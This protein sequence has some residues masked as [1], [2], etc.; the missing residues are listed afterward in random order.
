MIAA[1]FWKLVLFSKVV[2]TLNEPN[3]EFGLFDHV[4]SLFGCNRCRV[5]DSDL[6]IT[7]LDYAHELIVEL[8]FLVRNYSI[9]LLILGV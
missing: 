7:L 8:R 6:S 5:E 9:E 3:L 1:T 4:V 2:E